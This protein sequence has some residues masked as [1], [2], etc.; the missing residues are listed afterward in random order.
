M[1]ISEWRDTD[2]AWLG[3][4]ISTNGMFANRKLMRK[5]KAGREVGY[6]YELRS[7]KYS[8]MI[9]RVTELLGHQPRVT[10]QNYEKVPTVILW[11][12]ELHEVM[13]AIWPYLTKERQHEYAAIKRTSDMSLLEEVNANA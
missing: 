1:T 12:D 8:G 5:Q 10:N 11:G 4:V 9:K 2:K 7:K 6:R 13:K 3:G